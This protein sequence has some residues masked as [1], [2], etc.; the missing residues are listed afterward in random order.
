[1]IWADSQTAKTVNGKR[2]KYAI[3]VSKL[4]AITAVIW[5]ALILFRSFPDPQGT[6][7]YPLWIGA[8]AVARDA[9]PYSPETRA[10]LRTT[11]TVAQRVQVSDAIAYPLPAL[12]ILTPLTVLPLNAAVMVWFVILIASV[13]VFILAFDFKLTWI[14]PLLS[15][16]LMQAVTIKTSAVL[17]LGLIGLLIIAIKRKW[18]VIVGLCI[19]ILPAKPQAGLIIALVASIYELRQDCRV[20]YWACVW[21]LLLWGGSLILHP[22]WVIGWWE[23]VH[24][25]RE[26]VL[27]VSLLPE[28]L[29]IPIFSRNLSW[30]AIAAAVQAVSFPLNDIYASLPLLVGWMEMGGVF[31]IVGIGTSL[32]APLLFEHPNQPLALWLMVLVPYCACCVAHSWTIARRHSAL[33]R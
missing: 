32:S 25:Y 30:L 15:F 6:D 18:P 27:L 2:C 10:F 16:P 14:A 23:A 24:R 13:A 33:S 11:W 19:A 9:D 31:A 12:L 28:A 3:P 7:F 17:W 5:L 8:Q 4:A 26:Q 20:L 29:L 21:G 1:M 22:L